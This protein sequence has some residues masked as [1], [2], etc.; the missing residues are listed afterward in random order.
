MPTIASAYVNTTLPT[1]FSFIACLNSTTA[2]TSYKVR[3]LRFIFNA[4][5]AN[6]ATYPALLYVIWHASPVGVPLVQA[7]TWSSTLITSMPLLQSPTTYLELGCI[8]IDDVGANRSVVF[9]LSI[10]FSRIP[11]RQCTRTAGG[12]NFNIANMQT[13]SIEL[14]GFVNNNITARFE[15]VCVIDY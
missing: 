13:G 12:T 4:A 2:A 11:S 5:D 15:S 10:D 6:N 14:W 3:S 7:S 1:T 9:D 8:R